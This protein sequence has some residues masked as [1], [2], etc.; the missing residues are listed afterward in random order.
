MTMSS[1]KFQNQMKTGESRLRK[2]LSE[3]LKYQAKFKFEGVMSQFILQM[4]LSLC[5]FNVLTFEYVTVVIGELVG[6]NC[7]HVCGNFGYQV[8][9]STVRW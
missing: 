9:L 8:F 4:N 6:I 3:F 5:F 2:N 1:R 7:L